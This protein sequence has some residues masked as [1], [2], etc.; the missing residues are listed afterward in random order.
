[1]VPLF[2]LNEGEV[3]EV[4]EISEEIEH[5]KGHHKRHGK[6][7]KHGNLCCH[8][9]RV[10]DLGIRVGK[11]VTMLQKH[12]WGPMLVKVGDARIAIGRGMAERIKIKNSN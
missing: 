8:H 1:M 11:N 12:R 7:G 5:H 10:C 2:D 9:A 4:V 3:G 6:H